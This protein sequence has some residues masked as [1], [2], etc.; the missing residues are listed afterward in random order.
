[1][2]VKLCDGDA[3]LPPKAFARANVLP[4]E[5]VLERFA[6]LDEEG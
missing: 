4:I 1:M 6:A 2:V 3:P 5:Q